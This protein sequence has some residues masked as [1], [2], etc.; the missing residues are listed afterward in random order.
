LN[1]RNHRIRRDA[2]SYEELAQ[3]PECQAAWR[4]ALE[5]SREPIALRPV[6]QVHRMPVFLSR[7]EIDV[8]V[9]YLSE[10]ATRALAEGRQDDAAA[11]AGVGEAIADAARLE[12][13]NEDDAGI[14]CAW[15]EARIA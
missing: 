7:L 11:L 6:H 13:S 4:E 10:W 5:A 12:P 9:P 15:D 1:A 3:L 2:P 14:P 8:L